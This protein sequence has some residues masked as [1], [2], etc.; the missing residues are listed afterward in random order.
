[1]ST[2]LTV[3][4]LQKLRIQGRHSDTNRASIQ[5]DQSKSIMDNKIFTISTGSRIS[6]FLEEKTDWKETHHNAN[7]GFIA[8]RYILLF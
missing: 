1:M 3:G 8:L 6:A 5:K 4:Y 2:L 7:S